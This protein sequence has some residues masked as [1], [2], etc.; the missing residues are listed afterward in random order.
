MT[1]LGE[2]KYNFNR[3]EPTSSLFFELYEMCKYGSETSENCEKYQFVK[4]IFMKDSETVDVR[5]EMSLE[6]FISFFHD[7]Y[8]NLNTVLNEI[9][10]Q[11]QAKLDTSA[12]CDTQWDDFMKHVEKDR[13]LFSLMSGSEFSKNLAKAHSLTGLY[14]KYRSAYEQLQ[15]QELQASEK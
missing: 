7:K 11:D 5:K 14:N 9:A 13:K 1:L 8:H 15:Q 2:D 4:I 3:V 12:I 10:H 6:E